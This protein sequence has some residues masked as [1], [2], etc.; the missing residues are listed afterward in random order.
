M[1]DSSS[2]GGMFGESSEEVDKED[3]ERLEAN[4]PPPEYV[5]GEEFIKF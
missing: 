5:K 3:K 4:L 1:D 2:D